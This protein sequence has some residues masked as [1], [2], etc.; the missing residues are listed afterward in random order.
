V[1]A[2]ATHMLQMDRPAEAAALLADF[3][4]RHPIAG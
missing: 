4:K 1:L 2:D 3:L